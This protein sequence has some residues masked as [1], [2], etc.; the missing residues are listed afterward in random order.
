VSQRAERESGGQCTH[1][2][3]DHSATSELPFKAGGAN[4]ENAEA[5][6]RYGHEQSGNGAAHTKP[7][8]HFLQDRSDAGHDGPEVD[9][10]DD[11]GNDRNAGHP[12][13]KGLA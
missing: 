1:S 8:A 9:G 11:H 6:R 2:G 12:R 5:Q 4:P 3:K 7:V 13:P 10:G